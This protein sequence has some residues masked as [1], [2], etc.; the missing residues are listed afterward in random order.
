MTGEQFQIFTEAVHGRAVVDF[1]A[2]PTLD[3]SVAAR[4]VGATKVTAVDKEDFSVS[5]ERAA[6]FGVECIQITFKDYLET[7]GHEAIEVA[8]V[9]WPWIS[10]PSLVS[11]LSRAKNILYLGK[12]TDFVV[13]GSPKPEVQSAFFALLCKRPVLAHV[14]DNHEVITLYGEGSVDREL[15]AEERAALET[16][17]QYRVRRVPIEAGATVHFLHGC[18][19]PECPNHEA[20]PVSNALDAEIRLRCWYCGKDYVGSDVPYQN[21]AQECR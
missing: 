8:L 3:L 4:M 21:S 15:L 16:A 11:I 9:S 2:G 5:K 18:H 20:F 6:H 1:G 13:C 17:H 7:R 14:S 10:E 12:N 19:D